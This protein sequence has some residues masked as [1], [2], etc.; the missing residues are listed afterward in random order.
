MQIFTLH[1]GSGQADAHAVIV[2]IVGSRFESFTL[3]TATGW[4]RAQCEPSWLVK[5]ATDDVAKVIEAASQVRT[6][7]QQDGVGIEHEGRYYRCTAADPASA[8]SKD[9]SAAQGLAKKQTAFQKALKKRSNR[10]VP[11]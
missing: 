7:L 3:I 2:G 1:I 6:A 4:F 8:L 10:N 9:W 11:E 5:I